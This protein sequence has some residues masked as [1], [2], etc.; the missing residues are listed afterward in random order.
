[1][2]E[3]QLIQ[4][5]FLL[6][7]GQYNLN[8]AFIAYDY[9]YKIR[10][11]NTIFWPDGLM[12]E[13]DTKQKKIPGRNFLKKFIKLL[14][15]NPKIFKKIYV[16]GNLPQLSKKWLSKNLSSKFIHGNLPYGESKVIKKFF[17]RKKITHHSLVILT[18]PTPKQ[19]IVANYINDID[20]TCTILCIGGSINM[21]SNYEAGAPKI[22]YNLN[23]EWLW[24]LK[25]DTKRRFKRLIESL[26]LYS[27]SKVTGR[28][29]VF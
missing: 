21:C 26:T 14:N 3:Y 1:M 4:F 15:N 16:Y 29:K 25:F 8:L 11:H 23:L 27:I 7:L 13:I 6:Y 18:L 10:R 19:E 12:S 28:N 17:K 2:N 22:F 20:P 9:K 24:R 5:I